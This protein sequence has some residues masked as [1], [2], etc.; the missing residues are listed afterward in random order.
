MTEERTTPHAA[1]ANDD[2]GE[3][4]GDVV[5]YSPDVFF[6]MR[7]RTALKLMNLR[8]VL[9]ESPEDFVARFTQENEAVRM[10][11]VDMNR[12]VDWA[13]FVPA[14]ESDLPVVAFGSHTD[15]E[16]LKAAKQAGVD[17]VLSNGAL[18]S[19]FEQV[20]SRYAGLD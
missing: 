17:R 20:V 13:V 9:T 2:V 3:T 8:A 18:N 7:L 12:P 4:R 15:V 14:I 1:E 19:S 16:G 5:V 6:A 10:G 11:L